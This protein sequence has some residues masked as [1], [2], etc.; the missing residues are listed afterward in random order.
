MDMHS[1]DRDQHQEFIGSHVDGFANAT[2]Q[3]T[4]RVSDSLN[5]D[6]LW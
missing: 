2:K 4:D 5:M 1:G 3:Y 6:A